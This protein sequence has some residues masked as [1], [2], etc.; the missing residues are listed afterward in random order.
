MKYWFNTHKIY[1]ILTE[2]EALT[3]EQAEAI[4][5][6]MLTTRFVE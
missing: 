2:D 6:A 1:K 3:Q 5:A 4:I